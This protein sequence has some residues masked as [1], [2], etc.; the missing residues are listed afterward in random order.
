MFRKQ[1]GVE[2]RLKKISKQEEAS[3][4]LLEKQESELVKAIEEND[5]TVEKF[6]AKESPA[7]SKIKS[8]IEKLSHKLQ[9]LNH[10][11]E[12]VINQ[13]CLSFIDMDVV[14]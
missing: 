1:T 13:N 4:K 5:R 10:E 11:L 12:Q 8:E 3:L 9:K 6:L 14:F 7:E 2:K